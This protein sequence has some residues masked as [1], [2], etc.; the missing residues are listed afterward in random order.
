M[1]SSNDVPMNFELVIETLYF[2]KL[3]NNNVMWNE[4]S[5]MCKH[6]IVTL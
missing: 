2:H 3:N 6:I 4:K 5:Q 1:L